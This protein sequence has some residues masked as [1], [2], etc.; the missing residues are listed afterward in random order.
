MTPAPRE[1]SD[2]FLSHGRYAF[3]AEEAAEVLGSTRTTAVDAL[4]RLQQRNK[5]FSASKGLYVA[6]PPE[7]R[8]WGVL[9][10]EWIID[11]L[12]RHLHRPYYIALLSAARL[13]GASH[14]APQVF[15]AMT[16]KAPIRDR[17]LGRVRLRFY[18]SKHVDEDKIEQVAVP[19]G[20]ANVSAKETTVVDLITYHRASGGYGNVATV[21]REIGELEGAELARVASRRGRAAVRRTG[22]FVEHFGEVDELEALR[23][24]A[25]LDVGEPALLDPAGPKRGRTDPRW[26]VRMNAQVEADL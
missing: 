1:L 25:R 20:Y 2:Y 13:H 14:Q 16:T 5:V 12:M 10:G 17:D 11:A 19:T 3:T 18:A 15:Q 22:W 21:I 26:R 9:P 24:A 4:V 7:Y 8:S 6:V 23:Q